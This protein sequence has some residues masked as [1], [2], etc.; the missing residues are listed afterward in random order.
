MIFAMINSLADLLWAL[1]VVFLIAP[2]AL[3]GAGPRDGYLGCEWSAV[4]LTD[5][6]LTLGIF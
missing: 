1:Q 5:S 6:S 3:H 2:R 4:L